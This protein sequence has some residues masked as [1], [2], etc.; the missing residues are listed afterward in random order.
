[1]RLMVWLFLAGCLAAGALWLYP[2]GLTWVHAVREEA[3]YTTRDLA[4]SPLLATGVLCMLSATL[5]GAAMSWKVLRSM[6]PRPERAAAFAGDEGGA[7]IFEFALVFPFILSLVF[8]LFQWAE[9]LMADSLVHYAAFCSAR[10]AATWAAETPGGRF[11]VSYSDEKGQKVTQT[12]Q[13]ALYPAFALSGQGAA[14]VQRVKVSLL[15]QNGQPSNQLAL[16]RL[17]DGGK[18]AELRSYDNVGVQIDWGMKPRWPVVGLFFWPLLE[19]GRIPL[20]RTYRMEIEPYVQSLTLFPANNAYRHEKTR[21][22]LH[23]DL[24]PAE[25]MTI[26]KYGRTFYGAR[27]VLATKADGKCPQSNYPRKNPFGF[28]KDFFPD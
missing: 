18:P 10:T 5:I 26:A 21:Q 9:L 15:A 11:N 14:D 6:P 13:L 22:A 23:K 27:R 3:L 8:I 24:F 16:V 12:A 19:N 17:G 20:Q 25:H 4:A 2:A 28:F 7:L 1:M